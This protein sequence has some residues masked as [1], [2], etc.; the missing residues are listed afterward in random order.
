MVMTAALMV[1]AAVACAVPA[2]RAAHLD[3]TTALRTE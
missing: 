2:L 3:P 1:I